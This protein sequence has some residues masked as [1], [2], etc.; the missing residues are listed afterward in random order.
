MPTP[1]FLRHRLPPTP[2]R[3]IIH[4]DRNQAQRQRA[5]AKFAKGSAEGGGEGSSSRSRILVATD[6][7]ARGLDV[8]NVEHVVNYSLP[9]N[10][11][12]YIHRIGRTGR[13]GAQGIATSFYT[14][15]FQP[16][17]GNGG[18]QGG[19]VGFVCLVFAFLA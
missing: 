17:V 3:Q 14:P 12:T 9:K 16:H 19:W 1:T 6:V 10:F 8:P 2:P 15:G 18:W 11:T 5:L 4:A 13:A 7:A